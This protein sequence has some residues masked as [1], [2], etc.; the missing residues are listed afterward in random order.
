[1]SACRAHVE[2]NVPVGYINEM[3]KNTNPNTI[4]VRPDICIHKLPSRKMADINRRAGL[5]IFNWGREVQFIQ[6]DDGKSN[7][8]F[9]FFA[10][11]HLRRGRGFYSRPAFPAAV[12][13]LPGDCVLVSPSTLHRYGAVDDDCFVEDTVNFCGPLAELWFRSGIFRDGVFELGSAPLLHPIIELA[14]D[15]S[16]HAQL[17]AIFAL[18]KLF[19]DLYNNRFHQHNRDK[20]PAMAVL[21]DQLK[22][23]PARDWTVPEMAHFCDMSVN[24]FREAFT[25]RTGMLPKLYLDKLKV[26]QAT[27]LLIESSLTIADIANRVGFT[28]A[29][30]FSRRFKHLTG[31]AP[32]YY[33]EQFGKTGMSDKDAKP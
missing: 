27:T 6:P 8:Y 16:E 3:D 17:N 33:R 11:A 31:I 32:C 26:N 4:I 12:S 14:A 20:Y 24:R 2:T 30:H 9:E 5:W 21:I 23:D 7:R 18:N 19:L 28:D 15:P 29:F 13:M 25:K 10:I 22:D 1:M